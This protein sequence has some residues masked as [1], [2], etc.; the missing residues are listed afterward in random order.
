ML[1]RLLRWLPPPL[2][3]PCPATLAYA[4]TTA[5]A[6]DV[7]KALVQLGVDSGLSE[8]RAEDALRQLHDEGRYQRDVW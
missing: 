2:R 6:Q 8:A 3:S 4:L 1:L 7:H 5:P